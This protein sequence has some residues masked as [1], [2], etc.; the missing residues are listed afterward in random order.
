MLVAVHVSS[1]GPQA[2][3]ADLGRIERD[4]LKFVCAYRSR[5]KVFE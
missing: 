4:L 5:A 1:E 3:I 2:A